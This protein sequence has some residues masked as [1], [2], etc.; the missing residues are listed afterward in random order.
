MV[1]ALQDNEIDAEIIGGQHVRKKGFH[2][3]DPIVPLGWYF[4]SFQVQEKTIPSTVKF[5]H[6]D[7]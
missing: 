7:K 5:C 6:D 4:S 3:K 2:T 1:R